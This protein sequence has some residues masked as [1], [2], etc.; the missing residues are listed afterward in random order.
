[1]RSISR[2]R[3]EVR[4]GRGAE[5]ASD[6]KKEPALVA[7]ALVTEGDLDHPQKGTSSPPQL[8]ATITEIQY[9]T[10]VYSGST[11]PL[12]PLRGPLGHLRL[13]H[14]KTGRIPQRMQEY[15][16]PLRRRVRVQRQV[17][18]TAVQRAVVLLLHRGLRRG[19]LRA[20]TLGRRV[21]RRRHAQKRVLLA[22]RLG[23]GIED[24]ECLFFCQQ[25][26]WGR[27]WD[28]G[29]GL[30][31]GLCPGAG[32]GGSTPFAPILRR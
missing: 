18:L 3:V 13:E 6:G 5:T 32:P 30:S 10:T 21:G 26:S 24:R 16:E 19:L 2:R 20:P 1:M 9:I 12:P 14:P 11:L 25:S 28:L 27:G 15:V 29:L 8:F 31:H 17:A 22:L 23:G 7:H 4:R